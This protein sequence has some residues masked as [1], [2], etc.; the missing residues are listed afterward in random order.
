MIQLILLLLSI[1]ILI[2]GLPL[3]IIKLKASKCEAQITF[4][5]ALGFYLRKTARKSVFRAIAISQYEQLGISAIDLEIHFLAG[6]NP[7]LLIKALSKYRNHKVVNFQMLAALDLSNN[8]F[9][10]V[11]EKGINE[12][13]LV[14]IDHPIRNFQVSVFATFFFGLGIGFKTTNN[15]DV[16]NSIKKKLDQFGLNWES[17]ELSKTKQFIEKGVLND[18]Y[19]NKVL[20]LNLAQQKIQLNKS[21][22]NLMSK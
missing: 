10:E 14:I 20:C 12:Q 3:L 15:E 21:N 8:N 9:E 19:W 2:L 13:K 5:E 17:N 18:D 6:G 11:I 1:F 4:K 16:E 22:D 7:E